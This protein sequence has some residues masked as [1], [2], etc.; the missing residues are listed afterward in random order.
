MI[1]ILRIDLMTE[2]RK[3][4]FR[5]YFFEKEGCWEWMGIREERG[6]GIFR[7]KYKKRKVMMSA[8]RLAYWM[9]YGV[10]P[11]DT[12]L[13]VMHKCD[14][15]GCVR[16]DHLRLGTNRENNHDCV[17][18]GRAKKR[19]LSEE[20][21]EEIRRDC[22]PGIP[23]RSMNYYARKFGVTAGSTRC[24]YIGKTYVIKILPK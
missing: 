9:Y 2:E 16:P 11:D 24:I 19:M 20:Q 17:R 13:H 14:N 22:R 7:L 1:F 3:E 5:S 23:G 4:R 6:Y 10:N 8:H 15:P 18:K 12:G 21:A